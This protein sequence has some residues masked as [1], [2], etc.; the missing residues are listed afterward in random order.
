MV[1]PI[2]SPTGRSNVLARDELKPIRRP[3]RSAEGAQP[4]DLLTTICGQSWM[5]GPS[6]RPFGPWSGR[7]CESSQN[8]PALVGREA[9][10]GRDRCT[11]HHARFVGG[12][13]QGN[14]RD[15]LRLADAERVS[16]G[17]VVDAAKA[18]LV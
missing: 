6:T 15:V 3:E 10:F 9:A 8:H 16:L 5:Q 13:E 17:H 12:E 4:R 7:R 11:V 2:R 18:Y 1:S 14:V